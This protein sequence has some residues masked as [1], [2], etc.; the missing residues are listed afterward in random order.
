[1][2]R[3]LIKLVPG[4][5]QIVAWIFRFSLHGSFLLKAI[6]LF[7]CIFSISGGEVGFGS[8]LD[9]RRWT[10]TW[11]FSPPWAGVTGRT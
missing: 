6:P 10:S 8:E 2:D 9:R 3:C 11:G 7:V 5:I 4:E 1:M